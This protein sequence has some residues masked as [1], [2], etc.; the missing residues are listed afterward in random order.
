M[1]ITSLLCHESLLP[2]VRAALALGAGEH[3]AASELRLR[4]DPRK[5]VVLSDDPALDVVDMHPTV[6][7]LVR[8]GAA[9]PEVPRRLRGGDRLAYLFQSS[10]TSGLPKAMMIT[11]RNGLHSGLQGMITA[12]QNARYARV[13]PLTPQRVLGVIPMYHSYGMILWILRINLLPLTNVM[14]AKWDVEVALKTIQ[15]WCVFLSIG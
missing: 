6:E 10:G 7:A 12:V 4:L 8:R 14:L 1:Q 3:D 5:I 15:K 2:V 9:L 11:H 13:E